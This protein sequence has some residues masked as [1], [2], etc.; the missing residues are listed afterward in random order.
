[1]MYDPDYGNNRFPACK[2]GVHRYSHPVWRVTDG[3]SYFGTHGLDVTED[4]HEA[5]DRACTA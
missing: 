5:G 3:L 2:L 4:W 1:M